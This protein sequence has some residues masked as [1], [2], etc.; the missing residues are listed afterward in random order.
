MS[1][2]A[3]DLISSSDYSPSRLSG[4]MGAFSLMLTV[5]AFSA[6]LTTVSGYIPVSLMFG[7]IASPLIFIMATAVILIFAVGYISLNDAVKRPGDFYAFISFGLGK[8]LGLGSGFMAAVS[9]FLLLAGVASFFGVSCAELQRSITGYAMPWYAYTLI[10]W[11]AVAVMGYLNVELSAKVLTWVMFAEI[12]ICLAFAFGV[13]GAAGTQPVGMSPFTP[14]ELTGVGINVPFSM[15]FAVSFFMGFEATALFRDEVKMPEKTIPRATYGAIICIGLLYTVSAYALISAYGAD[16]QAVA[17]SN[18]A[19]M[20]SLA[21]ANFIS[22]RFHLLL[23]LMVLTSSFA[24][25]L[26]IH[27]V[28]SRYLHNLATDGALPETLK[29]VHVRH[30]SPYFASFTV[31][32]MVLLVLVP[33][34]AKGV[35]PEVL[36]GQLSGVGTA[37]VIILMTMVCLSSISYFLREGKK[38]RR[39]FSKLFLAPFISA[40]FF[41]WLVFL[42]VKNFEM[43]AGGEPGERR[44]MLYSLMAVI[45][46][47]AM[48][49]RYFK[50][51]KP[52][53][54][55]RLGRTYIS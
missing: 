55:A 34:I 27:N 42:V 5:L 23:T 52:D 37:G 29:K 11:L 28:L 1:I 41:I 20:F 46:A 50:A 15:L 3:K 14:S 53:V 19:S 16:T 26:S 48:A 10:C 47:G 8:S 35:K 17:T 45:A 38:Q 36:Y 49:A 2:E 32:V 25:V 24:C 51:R 43:L 31:S 21:F 40:S 6:P 13:F 22:P 44:W 54:F 33:F 30:L 7:G 9:Y 4:N 39:S 12:I 18:P